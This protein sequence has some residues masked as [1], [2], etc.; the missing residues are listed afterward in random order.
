M[1]K[2][3]RFMFVIPNSSWFGKRYWEWFTPAVTLLV[4]ILKNQGLEVKVLEANIDN[5]SLEQTKKGIEEYQPDVVG[6]SNMSIEYW[7]HPHYVAKITKE[8]NTC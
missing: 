5:L 7:R 1:K 8:I 3:E 2:I 4:P 6:I